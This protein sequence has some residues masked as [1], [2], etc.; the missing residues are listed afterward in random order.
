MHLVERDGAASGHP[1]IWICDA[2][3][4]WN[5]F[6]ENG[7]SKYCKTLGFPSLVKGKEGRTQKKKRGKRVLV[8]KK[9]TEGSI[10]SQRE[11]R[12]LMWWTQVRID[13]PVSHCWLLHQVGYYSP[14][15]FGG[16]SFTAQ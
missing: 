1:N 5:H 16:P 12:P 10:D 14:S 6:Y 15:P 4:G 11:K 8:P 7:L 13:L 2:C 9:A 3:S